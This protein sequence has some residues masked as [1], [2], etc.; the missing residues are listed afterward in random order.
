MILYQLQS[1]RVINLSIEDFLN[2]TDEMEQYL[3]SQNAGESINSPWHKS[4][5]EKHKKE[6]AEF[7]E[8]IS[9]DYYPDDENLKSESDIDINNIPD[10][11][12]DDNY[13]F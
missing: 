2:M 12:S 11:E 4:A 8:E 1:G 3:I 13:S 5:L 9:L 7:L 10:E 6:V